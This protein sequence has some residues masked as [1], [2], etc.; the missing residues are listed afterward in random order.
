MHYELY[1]DVWFLRNLLI[2]FLLLSLLQRI[3]KCPAGK[4][5]RLG[6]AALGSTGVCLLYV[7]SV[8][9]EMLRFLLVYVLLSTI[10]V[11]VGL[12]I[13]DRRMLGK[14][15]FLLY[16]S[17][18]LLGGIF[19]W[20][21]RVVPFPWYP[22]LGISLVSYGLLTAGM[23]GIL[24]IRDGRQRFLE[25]T[26]SFHGR[27][28]PVRALLDTGNRLK[29]PVFGKPVSII[30]E[31]VRQ[32]IC[33]EE[34]ILYYQVPFHSI[35]KQDGML[36]AFFADYLCIETPEGRK[37]VIERPMLGITKEPL[38]S[39]EKYDMILQPDLLS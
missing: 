36:P 33:Q 15:V 17:S 11:K 30:T 39:K 24:R 9:Q 20:V 16:V 6:A 1:I 12:H 26:V 3:L 21:Q 29:D 19:Q 38:S 10:M 32:K 18:M 25:V 4:L 23:Q 37:T 7:C 34:E 27:V 8:E 31:T 14:A 2:D 35:G 5:R 13:Q 22:F 28:I